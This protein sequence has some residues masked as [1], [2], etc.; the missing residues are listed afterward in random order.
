MLPLFG[1]LL[2]NAPDLQRKDV[3]LVGAPRSDE[4]TDKSLRALPEAANA[5][6][7]AVE[8]PKLVIEMA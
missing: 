8:L 3:R 1:A 2:I 6:A 4:S 7:Q 5:G